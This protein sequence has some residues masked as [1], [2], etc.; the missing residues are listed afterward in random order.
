MSEFAVAGR[1]YRIERLRLGEIKAL[2][3]IN[4]EAFDIASDKLLDRFARMVEAA[5][6]RFGAD[7]FVANDEAECTAAE[8]TAA[9]TMILRLS[10]FTSGEAAAAAS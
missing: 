6:A 9:A 3:R 5:T 7:G 8:L 10:G 1:V 2:A 4:E